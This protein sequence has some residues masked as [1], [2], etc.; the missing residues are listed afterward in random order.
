MVLN[1]FWLEINI[2]NYITLAEMD[3]KQDGKLYFFPKFFS[4][5]LVISFWMISGVIAEL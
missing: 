4:S 5:F 3:K 1:S 2:E